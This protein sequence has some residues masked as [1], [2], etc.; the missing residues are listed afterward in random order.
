MAKCFD[1][2][3]KRGHI[4]VPLEVGTLVCYKDRLHQGC[5]LDVVT[6]YVEVDEI[7]VIGVQLVLPRGNLLDNSLFLPLFVCLLEMFDIAESN[8]VILGE[9]HQNRRRTLLTIAWS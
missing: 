6:D 4:T 5:I 2:C 8:F 3:L 7:E 1:R 9:A